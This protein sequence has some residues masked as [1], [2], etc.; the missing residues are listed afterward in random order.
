MLSSFVIIASPNLSHHPAELSFPSVF[1][2]CQSTNI[3][4][5]QPTAATAP[6]ASYSNRITT[7]PAVT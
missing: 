7:T 4:P 1:V 3:R 2:C 6:A 5:Q